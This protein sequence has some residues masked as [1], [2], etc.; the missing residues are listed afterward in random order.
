[1]KGLSNTL[2][3]KLI[4]KLLLRLKNELSFPVLLFTHHLAHVILSNISFLQKLTDNI[5]DFLV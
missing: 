1:M 5:L 4:L 2:S 3:E